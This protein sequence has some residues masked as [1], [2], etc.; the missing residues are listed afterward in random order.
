MKKKFH[1]KA[2]QEWEDVVHEGLHFDM[3]HL[4]ASELTVEAKDKTYILI[5]TYGLHCFTKDDDVY[6]IPKKVK[7]S[8]EERSFNI[9]R[10][11]ASK[12]LKNILSNEITSLSFYQTDEKRNFVIKR[13]NS[14]TGL[15][16]PYKICTTFFK[17]NRKLRLHVISAYFV[18][19]GEGSDSQ[20]ITNRK[21][22][23]I[24][25]ILQD[26]TKK[27]KGNEAIGSKEAYR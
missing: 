15:D 5:V 1:I 17:E 27:S 18:R 22:S 13:H 24:Y 2:I 21:S 26:L 16:E 25:K 12:S 7:D 14:I 3:S 6:S 11:Q 10:Y 4:S 23:S 20:P 19:E 8:F 9:E